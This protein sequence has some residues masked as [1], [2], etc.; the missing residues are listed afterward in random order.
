MSG[1]SS[2]APSLTITARSCP[3][4][5]ASR[6]AAPKKTASRSPKEAA[7]RK[8]DAADSSGGADSAGA[9]G[10]KGKGSASA[11]YSGRGRPP[12][13][14]TLPPAPEIAK[15]S[16][17]ELAWDRSC[18]E[19]VVLTMGSKDKEGQA[20]V[21]WA[22][23]GAAPDDGAGKEWKSLA[24]LRPTP[25]EPPKGWLHQLLPDDVVRC[26]SAAASGR[27]KHRRRTCV[28]HAFACRCERC[29]PPFGR[30]RLS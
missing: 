23:P 6:G 4:A 18:Y 19:A 5:G 10:K 14:S 20:R 9:A 8:S 7:P 16:R 13:S 22:A 17:V 26:V 27:V 25:P 1:V 29:V 12:G 28:A 3:Q 30:T 2:L 11:V 21:H 15:G 24:E